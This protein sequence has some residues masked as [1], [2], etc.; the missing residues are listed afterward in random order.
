MALQVAGVF[1][2]ECINYVLNISILTA[3][4]EGFELLGPVGK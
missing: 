2:M 3:I 1:L 4:Y